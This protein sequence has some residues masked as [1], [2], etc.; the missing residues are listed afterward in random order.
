MRTARPLNKGDN[1]DTVADRVA[2]G[3]RCCCTHPSLH[4]HHK[5][6]VHALVAFRL[7]LTSAKQQQA[8]TSKGP[9]GAVSLPGCTSKDQ[10]FLKRDE[11]TLFSE[12]EIC[13]NMAKLVF[14]PMK[15]FWWLLIISSNLF[16]VRP[17]TS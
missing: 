6:S 1:P 14:F 10:L 13:P 2:G 7:L 9:V 8:E 17:P 11:V 16:Q 4:S 12:K 5:K 15:P 3:Y